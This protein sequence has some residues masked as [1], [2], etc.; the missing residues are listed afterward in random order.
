MSYPLRTLILE[1]Q[2]TDM[3][4]MLYELRQAG[5]EPCCWHAQTE[6]T[7]LAYLNADLDIILAD[8]SLPQFNALRALELLQE[9]GLNIPFI[10]VTGSL[11]EEA[12]VEC[13]KRGAADY[14]IKDRLA[15]LGP[16]V[17]QALQAKHLRDQKQTA[18]EQVRR[19]NR[20]LTLLNRII[21]ASVAG[22]EEKAIL[23]N[24]CRELAVTLNVPLAVAVLLNRDR[25]AVT[26][27]TE[28]ISGGNLS[29]LNR[30][31]PIDD[32]LVQLTNRKAPLVIKDLPHDTRLASLQALIHQVGLV[33]LLFLPLTVDDEVVGGL[34]LGTFEQRTFPVDNI[35][36]IK[37]VADQ[38]SGVVA[39]VR[40]EAE[41]RRLST[42][43]EQTLD[44]VII[45]DTAGT[46]L[47]VN[48]AFER[49]TG[50]RR[51]EVI[52]RDVNP[53]WSEK[54]NTIFYEELWST[55]QAG[56]NWH[57]RLVN[58]KA[59]GTGYTTDAL[60][61]PVRDENGAV[62]N[63]VDV[64]R[65]I[66]PELELEQRYMQAQKMEAVGRLAGG[67]AHDFNNVLTAITGYTALALDALE[68][69]HPLYENL[70]E[71]K[72]AA[73]RAAALTKQ[74]LIFSRKQVLQFEVLD[75]N[76]LLRNIEKMLH[77]L[78]GEDIELWMTLDP[79]LGMIKADAGQ[80]EQVIMNLAVNARD[81]MPHGGRLTLETTNIT[82]TDQD[83]SKLSDLSPGPY[84]R[85]TVSD[86]GLGMDEEVRL[87]VFEPFFTTKEEGMGT[88]LGLATVH[89][90]IKQ[91]G[92]DIQLHSELGQGTKFEIFL[93]W[94][95]KYRQDQHQLSDQTLPRGS[96]TILLVE[97]EDMVRE[98][99]ERVL[100]DQGY[101]VLSAAHPVA[102]L[103]LAAE[104]QGTIH[105]LITDVV[106]PGMGGR[107]LAVQ[108]LTS[109]PETQV[110]YVSGYTDDT[111]LRHG[112]MEAEVAFLQKPFTLFSLT[113]KVREMLNST[114]KE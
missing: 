46:I 56:K 107:D 100:L 11:S 91:S 18:E 101:T 15:R 108:L 87:H 27:V 76:D 2:E 10:V 103:S 67:V 63:Y 72:K 60:I 88:G 45:T 17:R 65:D 74:L 64:Q 78:I 86:T 70:I 28:Y 49:I 109:R 22:L 80:I 21:A 29:L 35:S 32:S 12:A 23:E 61:S 37:S 106:M 85:L 73:S 41:R 79:E 50:Y 84:V 105:L 89:S 33:S 110:L 30:S 40:L 102:G 57:G 53:F 7:Y 39:R 90:I 75:L 38:L 62:I 97:D 51:S 77:R 93:P 25:T 5:F 82:I 16:A 47:Y 20:E 44:S 43:I 31:I 6:T 52:G 13:M 48:P 58:K 111:I 19:R 92:G 3:E 68:K 36:L 54:H 104:Y 8:Y 81:A 26:V 59:D 66:T 113:S 34:V 112:L 24:A 95:E 55:L 98:L 96:E 83:F 99:A 114:P 9:R 71:V 4:L 1:D 94:I 14:L 42:A 69:S